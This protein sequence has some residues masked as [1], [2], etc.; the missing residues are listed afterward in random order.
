MAPVDRRKNLVR[1]ELGSRCK[2]RRFRTRADSHFT[3]LAIDMQTPIMDGL[4]ARRAFRAIERERGSMGHNL[5]T[6]AVPSDFPDLT[7]I[8][9]ALEYSARQTDPGPLRTQ[10]GLTPGLSV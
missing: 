6:A 8:G 2:R 4:T 1:P 9:G 3:L 10:V 5:K 7:R